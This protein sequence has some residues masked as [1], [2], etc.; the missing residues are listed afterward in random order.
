MTIEENLIVRWAWRVGAPHALCGQKCLVHTT[1]KFAPRDYY[2]PAVNFWQGE[3]DVCAMYSR[4][5]LG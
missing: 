2:T 1:M 4:V 5:V 3:T